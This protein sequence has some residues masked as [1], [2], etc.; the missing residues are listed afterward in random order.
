MMALWLQFPGASIEFQPTDW[1]PSPNAAHLKSTNWG[2]ELVHGQD[3]LVAYS[4]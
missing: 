1:G 3:P 2:C 4:P